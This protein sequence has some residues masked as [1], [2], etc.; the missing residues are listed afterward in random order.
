M[1]FTST[2]LQHQFLSI[3]PQIERVAR[4]A[5]RSFPRRDRDEAIAEVVAH[6]WASFARLIQRGKNPLLFPTALAR[7]SARSLKAGKLVGRRCNRRDLVSPFR[8]KSKKVQVVSLDARLTDRH[9]RWQELLTDSHQ[10]TPADTA[11]SRIDF[12]GWL[13]S[14]TPRS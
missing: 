12:A 8:S 14:L 1:N 3:L 6:A 5:F 11:A 13:Q 2:Q 9:L 4:F 7:F 10:S